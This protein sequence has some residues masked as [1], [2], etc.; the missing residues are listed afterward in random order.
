MSLHLPDAM[1][2][3]PLYHLLDA[4]RE[5]VINALIHRDYFET[6]SDIQIRVFDDRVLITNPGGLPDELTVEDL[7]AE[8]HAS[9]PRNPLLA[10]VFYYAELIEKWGTGTW[11]MA[12]MCRAQGLPAP[13]FIAGPRRFEAHFIAD[14]YT[15]DRLREMGITDRQIRAVH[16]VKL[17]G[18]IGNLEYQELAGVSKRTATRDLE[19][20]AQAGL[21]SRVGGVGRTVRYALKEPERGQRGHKGATK[22]PKTSEGAERHLPAGRAVRGTS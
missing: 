9:C 12:Q 5:A 22:G 19:A 2:R 16:H 13:D 20:L 14:P 17:K 6:S 8:H 4:L 18:H 15:E 11:R 1:W 3:S 21:L 7:K 10:Q